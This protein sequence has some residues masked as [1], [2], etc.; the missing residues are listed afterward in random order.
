MD[1]DWTRILSGFQMEVRAWYGDLALCGAHRL[2][3]NLPGTRRRHLTL[4][5]VRRRHAC[6]RRC[7]RRPSRNRPRQI[8]YLG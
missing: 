2:I 6:F 1:N 5:P 4:A 8:A 7:V 3:N